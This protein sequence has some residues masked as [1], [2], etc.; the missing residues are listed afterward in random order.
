MTSRF[1]IQEATFRNALPPSFGRMPVVLVGN[2]A[3][4][5]LER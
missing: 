1:G 5:S 4:L 3:D 2:K